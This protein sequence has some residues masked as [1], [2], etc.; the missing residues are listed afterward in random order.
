MLPALIIFTLSPLCTAGIKLLL[1]SF[2]SKMTLITRLEPV[3]LIAG[4]TNVHQTSRL[5]VERGQSAQMDCSHNL[6]GAYFQMS[7]YRRLPGDSLTQI[8]YTVPFNSQPDF[9]DFS[10]DKFSATKTEA[11]RGSFTV[12]KVQPG[13]RGVYFCAVSSLTV[14]QIFVKLH[15]N[16]THLAQSGIKSIRG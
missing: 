15:K 5:V 3:D 4:S 16:H 13:D 14:M 9:G 11:E 7:W 2:K 12:K 8:V 6:G 1:T 10:P